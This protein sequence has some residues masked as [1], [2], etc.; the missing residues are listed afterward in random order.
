MKEQRES[1]RSCLYDLGWIRQKG[2]WL[3]ELMR[4]AGRE[5]EQLDLDGMDRR[6][7]AQVESGTAYVDGNNHKVEEAR[8][9]FIRLDTGIVVPKETTG[10]EDRYLIIKFHRNQYDLWTGL[11]FEY[12]GI[13][14]IVQDETE[15][16]KESDPFYDDIYWKPGW[17]DQL[18]GLVVDEPW[19]NEYG[20][21]GRLLPFLRYT[22]RKLKVDGN[23]IVRSQDGKCLVFNTGL[24]THDNL[25]PIVAVCSDNKP[26]RP[27]WQFDRFV[28]WS[29]GNALQKDRLL[30]KRFPEGFVPG[31][32]D[33]FDKLKTTILL[34]SSIREDW[35]KIEHDFSLSRYQSE[36][37]MAIAI[38]LDNKEA[39]KV[40][41]AL[42]RMDEAN[43]DSEREMRN[44]TVWKILKKLGDPEDVRIQA[45]E[46]VKKSFSLAL[47]RLSW[48]VGT[49]VPMW[50]A[51]SKDGNNFS[52][53]LPLSF[54]KDPLHAD[55]VLRLKPVRDNS[56]DNVVYRPESF[57]KLD[58][59]YNKARLLRRVEAF[60]LRDY[61]ER[62]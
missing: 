48:E 50:E 24:V 31:T 52:F 47:R 57:L 4:F 54:G 12:G 18:L 51:S 5:G 25:D 34:P 28:I 30:M 15:N 39:I 17:Q 33:W 6:M 62:Q 59:A 19:D 10:D 11:D 35:S 38:A 9:A 22:Y 23:K 55:V 46:I 53:M 41:Q 27:D 26:R 3:K 44:G 14:E 56:G 58:A 60:W 2:M 61:V 37:L 32:A 29:K 16:E 49:A 43:L 45:L 36:L 13:V 1:K 42:L 8:A 21:G 7:R 40:A 20:P